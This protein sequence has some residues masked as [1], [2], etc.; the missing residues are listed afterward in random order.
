M[1]QRRHIVPQV[2]FMIY[3]TMGIF[4]FTEYNCIV[5][6]LVLVRWPSIPDVLTVNHGY[7]GHPDVLAVHS[8]MLSLHS[9]MLAVHPDMLTVH[10]DVLAAHP[11]C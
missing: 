6:Y 7:D 2:D 5:T 8:E 11:I 4:S 9:D 10:L 1:V 3:Q